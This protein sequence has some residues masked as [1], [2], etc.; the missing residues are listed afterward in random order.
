MIQIVSAL[1]L[2]K[3]PCVFGYLGSVMINLD[4]FRKSLDAHDASDICHWNRVAV[5]PEPD[6]RKGIDAGIYASGGFKNVSRK[7]TEGV[8]FRLIHDTNRIGSALD[9]I[10]GQQVVYLC[11]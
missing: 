7:R 1:I 10:A 8:L 11:I 5:C 2:L 3:D 9:M 6:S 4:G